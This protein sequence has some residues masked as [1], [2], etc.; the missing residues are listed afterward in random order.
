MGSQDQNRKENTA[1]PDAGP[2]GIAVDLSVVILSVDAGRPLVQAMHGAGPDG[3]PGDD[4]LPAG[5]FDPGRHRTLE[6]GLRA[7]AES[8]AR[9]RLGYVEQLYTFGDK[10]RHTVEQRGGPR[11]LSIGYLALA[12]AGSDRADAPETSHWQDWYSYFPWEDRRGGKGPDPVL[13]T[14]LDAWVAGDP[15]GRQMRAALAFGRDGHEFDEERVLDRYELLYE[16]R[17]V[18]EA[19]R[20]RAARGEAGEEPSLPFG[21]PMRWD[22]RRILATAISRLRGKLKYRPLVFELMPGRFTLFELQRTVE[23]ITG[24]TLHK[25]NFRRQVETQ[26]L[27]EETGDLRAETGGRPAKLYRFRRTA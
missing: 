1:S 2:G 25:Q 3:R 18:G 8:Q 16:A 11:V 15:A 14:A 13:E 24:Q 4:A 10:D 17:L 19:Q 22:H 9:I 7:F 27:V 12:R 5:P 6:L 26:G 23:A 21:R 20:D